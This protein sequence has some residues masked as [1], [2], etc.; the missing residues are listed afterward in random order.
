MNLVGKIFTMLILV[1]SIMFMVFAIAV[2]RTTR[3]SASPKTSV[4]SRSA[5]EAAS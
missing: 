1:L 4:H 2:S 5:K 3:S